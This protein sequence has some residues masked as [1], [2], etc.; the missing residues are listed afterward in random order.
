MPPGKKP[1]GCKWIYK[2]KYNA[3]G[4]FKRFKARLVAKG[5]SQTEGIN[6]HKTFSP[7]V[8]MET[9]RTVLTIVASRK[10]FIHQIDVHNAFLQGDLHDEIYMELPQ[11][12]KSQGGISRYA[13]S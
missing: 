12:F 3:S 6:Y 2:I 9:L 1:I 13:S 8:M 4:E 5:Y 11:G 10:W 7:V